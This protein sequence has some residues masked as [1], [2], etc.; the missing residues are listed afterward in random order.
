MFVRDLKDFSLKDIPLIGGKA[1][2]L[3]EM[4]RTL[5][6]KGVRIPEGFVITTDAY[7]QVMAHDNIGS[8]ITEHVKNIDYRDVASLRSVAAAIRK[9][10]LG[11][12]FSDALRDEILK[13]YQQLSTLYKETDLPV[14]VRSSATAEDLPTAS[15][16]GQQETYLNVRGGEQ[17]LQAVRKTM[18]SLFTDRAIVYRQEHGISLSGVALAVCVQKMVRTDR[19]CSGVMFTLDPESGFADVISIAATYGLGELLV[20]GTVTPDEYLLYKPILRGTERA[21]IRKQL[22]TKTEMLMATRQGGIESSPVPEERQRL[23]AVTDTELQE[24]AQFGCI[25]EEHMTREHGHWTPM[26]IEWAKDGEDGQLYIVQARPETTHDQARTKGFTHYQLTGSAPHIMTMGQSIGQGIVAGAVRII[27]HHDQAATFQQGEIL[28]TRM[29]NPDWLPIMRKAGGIITDLGGRTCHAAIISRELGIPAVIGTGNATHLL[30]D[31]ARVTVDCSQGLQGYV[32]YGDV[33][34]TTATL[35]QTKSA[36][37]EYELLMNVAQPETAFRSAQLPVDGVG[38]ARLEFIVSNYIG[39]HPLA[40]YA[41]ETIHDRTT[42]EE[43]LAHVI[44]Y[45]TAQ[46]YVV[47]R[48]AEGIA[49]IA[50]AFYPRPVIIRFSDLKTNEYRNLLGGSW[51]E[52]EEENP[53]LGWRGAARYVSE[54]Y[55]PAFAYECAALRHVREVWGFT[56]IHVMVPFVRSVEEAARVTALIAEQ[57]L[58][59]GKEGLRWYMMVEIPMNV[60]LLHQFADMF[61]GFSIGSN[62]L[63]QLTLGVDRDS[64]RLHDLFDERNEAVLTLISQAI[65]TAH[66]SGKK[67]GIC[68]EAPSNYPEVAEFLLKHKIDSI[69]LSADAVPGFLARTKI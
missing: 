7:R 11:V 10:I 57:G 48:L 20:Q 34:Y 36:E 58:P 52:P 12:P 3:S 46:N 4:L 47:Q 19:G 26:D 28:V 29:T 6:G 16:A 51:F 55:Q 21:I 67:I 63:T 2:G 62:D 44:S 17:L 49:T 65:I 38:L 40:A 31:G 41:P 27:E 32:Y 59:R 13:S 8:R 60:I 22:G 14:A 35:P 23:F 37:R 66:A 5:T 24:L 9:L 61:D 53:M 69:S 39:I 25:I 54:E 64:S 56:N 43:I 33:S 42:Q 50:A 15:F 30:V 18:A 1:A 45:G 68:G